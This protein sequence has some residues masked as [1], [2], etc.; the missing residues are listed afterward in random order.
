MLEQL[1]LLLATPIAKAILNKFY[2]DIGD[3]LAEKAVKLLPENT[4][5]DRKRVY[6]LYHE[7]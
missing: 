3:K 1:T 4:S 6:D 5:E 7:N 2:E